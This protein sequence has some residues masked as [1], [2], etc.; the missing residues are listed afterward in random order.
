M[1][2]ISAES[3]YLK[4]HHV[5]VGL[6]LPQVSLKDVPLKV[7]RKEAKKTLFLKRYE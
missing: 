2:C 1:D 4:N 7:R 3:V 5:E 6:R